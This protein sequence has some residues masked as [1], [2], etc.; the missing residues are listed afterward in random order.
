M[1]IIVLILAIVAGG[2]QFGDEEETA[3]ANNNPQNCITAERIIRPIRTWKVLK[4]EIRYEGKSPYMEVTVHNPLNRKTP[5]SIDARFILSIDPGN[6]S[7]PAKYN[8]M[9]ATYY[10]EK[11]NVTFKRIYSVHDVTVKKKT[12]KFPMQTPCFAR[13]VVQVIEFT[14]E[15]IK[16]PESSPD[17]GTK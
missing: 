15:E 6:P 5:T 10:N 17:G 14:P 1:K 2:F 16:V 4:T 7:D 13:E 12:Q 9:V 3:Q 8:L 11:A